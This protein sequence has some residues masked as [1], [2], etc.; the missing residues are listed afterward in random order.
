MTFD[1]FR[2]QIGQSINK[3]SFEV[4]CPVP[5]RNEKFF[6]IKSLADGRIGTDKCHYEF[7]IEEENIETCDESAIF[8]IN[9]EIHFDG[10]LPDFISPSC[11]K[12][13]CKK[14]EHRFFLVSPNQLGIVYKQF[15]NNDPDLIEKCITALEE[16]DYRFQNEFLRA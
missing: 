9:L 3:H 14:L 11:T 12:I 10:C 2:T 13:L 8:T 6:W 5:G 15:K 4:V 7:A 16:M 1:A